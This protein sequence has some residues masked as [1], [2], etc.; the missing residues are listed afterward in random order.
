MALHAFKLRAVLKCVS[1]EVLEM[2]QPFPFLIPVLI[3]AALLSHLKCTCYP[4]SYTPNNK[5]KKSIQ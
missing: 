3:S 1:S 5:P 4:M 2:I